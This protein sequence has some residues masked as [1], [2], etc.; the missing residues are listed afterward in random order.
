MNLPGRCKVLTN[1][2]VPNEKL[3]LA[4]GP[5]R[6]GGRRLRACRGANDIAD[7]GTRTAAACGQV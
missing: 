3:W 4:G 1:N 2:G 6:I 5:G 7:T